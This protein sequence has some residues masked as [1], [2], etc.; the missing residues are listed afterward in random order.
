MMNYYVAVFPNGDVALRISLR[1]YTAAWRGV[2][3]YGRDWAS[4]PSFAKDGP[5]A[6]RTASSYGWAR[7]REIVV[8]RAIPRILYERLK[9]VEGRLARQSLLVEAGIPLA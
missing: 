2:R 9:K 1:D 5:T 7:E 4:T 8:A 3:A 6:E